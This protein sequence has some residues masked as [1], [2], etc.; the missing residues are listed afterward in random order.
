MVLTFSGSAR[1]IGPGL[2]ICTCIVEETSLDEH[3]TVQATTCSSLEGT[4]MQPLSSRLGMI[5]A[6]LTCDISACFSS[7]GMSVI[8]NLGIFIVSL[9]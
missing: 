2:V 7:I 5:Y 8:K 4:R 9:S 1:R 3:D 6:W